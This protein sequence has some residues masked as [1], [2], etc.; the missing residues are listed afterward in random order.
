MIDFSTFDTFAA[1]RANPMDRMRYL[2]SL[3]FKPITHDELYHQ[4]GL[5]FCDYNDGMQ[6]A[7]TPSGTEVIIAQMSNGKWEVVAFTW[8]HSDD[9]DGSLQE[10][11]VLDA[12]ELRY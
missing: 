3:E 9:G 4:H 11:Y 6:Y 12:Q 7:E 5:D 1:I 10:T 2:L 8:D